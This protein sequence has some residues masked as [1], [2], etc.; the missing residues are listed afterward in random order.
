MAMHT[1]NS[2]SGHTERRP[3]LRKQ[4]SATQLI[5]DR[6]PFLVIG[7]ELHNSS[8]S[9]L[10]YMRPVWER[11]VALHLNTVLAP[12]SWEL[13][14]PEEGKFDFSL[15]D[16]LIH[17]AR[18]HDLRLILLWF[19]S[20]KNGMSSYVPA[21]LKRDYHRFP[22][23]QLQGGQT[24]EVLSPLA[25][26]NWQADARAFAR[27]MR[28]LHEV[29]D[30]DHTVVMVQVENEVGVL[31]DSRDRSDAANTAFSGNVPEELLDQLQE[32][33]DE[34]GAEIVSRWA[35]SGFAVSGTWEEVFGAGPET[36]ELF[37]AWSYAR[38]IDKVTAAGKF[39]YDLPMFVNAWLSV[40]HQKPGTWPSGG[41]LPHT[42]D[43]WLAGAPHVDI[44]VPDIYQTD[45]QS[46]CQQYT[47]R[48]NP[49]FIP[50]MRRDI[51][52]ARNV[53]YAIGEY[54]AIGTS[55][56]AI[57]SI[58]QGPV[59]GVG[60]FGRDAIERPE[61]APISKSYA[62]LRRLAPLILEHQGKDAIGGFL[63]DEEHPSVSK[64]MGGYELEI[65][66]DQGFGPRANHGYGLII[67]LGTDEF[68]GAGAGFMVRFRALTPGPTL[69]GIAAVDEG[70][71]RSG[72]WIPGRRLNGDETRQGDAWRFIESAE[73]ISIERCT[74]YRYE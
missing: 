49:L 24:V 25:E 31:G 30:Q 8:S 28:H 42:L 58:A 13:V 14:E 70:E 22:R 27:L 50:E 4:G 32:H 33:R 46:W 59:T 55:P 12:V 57:D 43:V 7:G 74:V 72:K 5:V 68:I 6:H 63:L 16:G 1:S 54:D 44:L 20:W 26:A 61:D 66:L 52:G 34:L 71:Y 9:S 10:D 56:F 19:G 64:Q 29:D 18:R 73:R 60:L 39:E 69:A 35:S 62:S 38:Y 23:V 45:F 36:D 41:P 21:W 17:E 40:A 11:L 53:F 47:R 15:L 2:L 3:H 48:G 67:S 65:T 51:E 37:M